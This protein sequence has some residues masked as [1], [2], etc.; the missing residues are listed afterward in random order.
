VQ[1]A[2]L[3]IALYAPTGTEIAST[4][5]IT[6][7]PHVTLHPGTHRF[8]VTYRSM[9]LVPNS[10]S[11]GVGLKSNFGMEDHLPKA[12]SLDVVESEASSQSKADTFQGYIVPDVDYVLA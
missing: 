6:T 12:F 8:Q 11:F 1:A 5:S 9:K 10:Y 4:S 2:E 7:H 3:G